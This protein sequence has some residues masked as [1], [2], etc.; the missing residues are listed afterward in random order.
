MPVLLGFSVEYEDADNIFEAFDARTLAARE[1]SSAEGRAGLADDPWLD[2]GDCF[3]GVKKVVLQA[4][5]TSLFSDSYEF[6]VQALLGAQ[7]H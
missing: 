4:T 6:A 2:A 1:Q 5:E 7:S 3:T